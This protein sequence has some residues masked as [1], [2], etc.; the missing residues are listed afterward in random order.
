MGEG[1]GEDELEKAEEGREGVVIV[2]RPHFVQRG[3]SRGVSR[4]EEIELLRAERRG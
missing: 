1:L 3:D 2:F 4:G